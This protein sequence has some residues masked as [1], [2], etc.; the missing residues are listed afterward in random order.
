MT[1]WTYL[2]REEFVEL[3]RAGRVTATGWVDD[4]TADGTII[5]ICQKDGRGRVMIHR[6][7]K[8]D[9]WRID[10]RILQDREAPPT[11]KLT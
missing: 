7:D 4:L 8:F 2:W 10:S 11:R 3:R 6:N 9:I 5:W 1:N